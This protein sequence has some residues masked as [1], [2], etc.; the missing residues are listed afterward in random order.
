MKLGTSTAR[1]ALFT[2]SSMMHL[3]RFGYR[4]ASLGPLGATVIW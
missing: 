3:L 1:V 4:L 2:M